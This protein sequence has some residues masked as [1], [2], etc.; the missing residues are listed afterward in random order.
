MCRC[1][2]R[3][4]CLGSLNHL[5]ATD[6]ASEVIR[7][8]F[9][10]CVSR[11]VCVHA[12]SIIKH[13]FETRADGFFQRQNVGNCFD[14]YANEKKCITFNCIW[15]M[16][17]SNAVFHIASYLLNYQLLPDICNHLSQHRFFFVW[18]LDDLNS[19]QDRI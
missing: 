19:V 12:V 6:H 17:R 10:K 1:V 2:C 11:R 4:S 5:N 7:A 13:W 3:E 8:A 18:N 15:K 9:G 14:L 16:Y